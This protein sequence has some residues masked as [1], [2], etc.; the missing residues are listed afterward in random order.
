MV[1]TSGIFLT[2]LLL[3]GQTNFLHCQDH[4][5][6]SAQKLEPEW[7]ISL[8]KQFQNCPIVLA[9][10]FLVLE[11]V[12]YIILFKNVYDHNKDIQQN[13]N[14]LGLS[15]DTLR[16]RQKKNVITLFGQCL[17]FTI[18]TVCTIFIAIAI[19]LNFTTY[20]IRICFNTMLVASYFIASPELC[21]FYFRM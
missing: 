2:G 5:D 9:Q 6:P 7:I 8:G 12:T 15:A 1:F 4:D 13:R 3:S 16:K 14:S 21:Q 20:N 19:Q 10:I 17:S 11:L 18:E